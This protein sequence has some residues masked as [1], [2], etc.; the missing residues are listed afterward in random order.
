MFQSIKMI[1]E[2]YRSGGIVVSTQGDATASHSRICAWTLIQPDGDVI[3][4]VS[5]AI[6]TNSN[7]WKKH[8]ENVEQ[9]VTT[10]RRFRKYLQWVSVSSAPI[11]MG[12]SYATLFHMEN[13]SLA[14]MAFVPGT[15]LSISLFF[16]RTLIGLYL[17]R[18]ILYN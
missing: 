11:F 7:C 17:R 4:K 6:V 18:R 9:R 8:L 3:N 5:K 14:L 16:I 12:V 1:K 10:L 15:I 2:M 13:V